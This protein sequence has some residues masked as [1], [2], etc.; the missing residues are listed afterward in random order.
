MEQWAGMVGAVVFDMIRELK[1]AVEDFKSG[2]YDGTG[3]DTLILDSNTVECALEIIRAYKDFCM[4]L[5]HYVTADE[6]EDFEPIRLMLQD[7]GYILKIKDKWEVLIDEEK[8]EESEDDDSQE[9][10]GGV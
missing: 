7:L 6:R 3:D 4:W 9:P 2:E 10:V 5:A 1:Q 8:L